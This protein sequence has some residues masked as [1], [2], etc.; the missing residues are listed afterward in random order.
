MMRILCNDPY[1]LAKYL[2]IFRHEVNWK[3][4]RCYMSYVSA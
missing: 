2:Y 1:V 4:I 3:W